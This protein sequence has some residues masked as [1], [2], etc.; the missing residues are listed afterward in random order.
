MLTS[1]HLLDVKHLGSCQGVEGGDVSLT[2][3]QGM[4]DENTSLNKVT[5][6]TQDCTVT[7]VQARINVVI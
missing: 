3:K 2:A 6:N 5:V 7:V 4:K 1:D